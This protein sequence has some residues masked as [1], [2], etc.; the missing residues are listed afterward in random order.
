MNGFFTPS[1]DEAEMSRKNAALF[2]A[3]LFVLRICVKFLP[4]PVQYSDGRR[5]RRRET[6]NLEGKEG[7]GKDRQFN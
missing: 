2:G 1:K 4:S 7:S 6:L 5:P 3:V